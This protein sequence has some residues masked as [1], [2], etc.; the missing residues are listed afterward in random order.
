MVINI[1]DA[2]RVVNESLV[3][4]CKDIVVLSVYE[5]KPTSPPFRIRE[6]PFTITDEQSERLASVV[7]SHNLLQYSNR[8]YGINLRED[9]DVWLDILIAVDNRDLI[10]EN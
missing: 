8:F 9:I 10:Y 4:V 2:Y 6:T 7:T 5:E 1:L 3:A